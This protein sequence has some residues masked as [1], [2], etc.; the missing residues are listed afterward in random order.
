VQ[1]IEFVEGFQFF[2]NGIWEEYKYWKEA[3][4]KFFKE[5]RIIMY[6]KEYE[7]KFGV[8]PTPDCQIE[9]IDELNYQLNITRN[10]QGSPLWTI[11]SLTPADSTD[12]SPII[13]S[14]HF[15]EEDFLLPLSFSGLQLYEGSYDIGIE[16]FNRFWIESESSAYVSTRIYSFVST[17]HYRY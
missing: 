13:Y 11:I 7:R 6:F 8:T 15:G 5:K 10:S 3:G 9:Q 1:N 2:S 16:N 17:A 14:S 12:T 4:K